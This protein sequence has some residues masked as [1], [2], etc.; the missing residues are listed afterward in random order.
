MKLKLPK[1]FTRRKKSNKRVKK[2]LKEKYS[3]YTL[4]ELVQSCDEFLSKDLFFPA[5]MYETGLELAEKIDYNRADLKKL[6][7]KLVD[8]PELGLYV[9]ALVNKIIKE[10]EVMELDFKDEFNGLGAY[11]KQ[12]TLIINNAKYFAGY[13]MEGGKIIIRNDAS[14]RVGWKMKGGNIFIKG[15]AGLDTGG[16]MENGLIYVKGNTGNLAGFNM[17]NGQ[18]IISGK[19]GNNLGKFMQAGKII[20]RGDVGYKVGEGM[21]GGKI[22]FFGKIG[23]IDRN[24]R[25]KIYSRNKLI[26]SKRIVLY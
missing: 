19:S 6:C 24:C 2:I 11:L 12:G 5:S 3:P 15:D 18:I 14:D 22:R 17:S 9:S 13:H 20:V 25:G 8:R 1:I 7:G 21:I 4:T 16:Y 10:T 26:W 23:S